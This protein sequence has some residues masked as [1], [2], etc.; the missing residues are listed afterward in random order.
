M[1]GVSD[2]V[3]T[4]LS[5]CAKGFIALSV[6][7]IYLSEYKGY[8]CSLKANTRV[9]MQSKR[10]MLFCTCQQIHD[11]S[12]INTSS[13]GLALRRTSLEPHTVV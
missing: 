10:L 5:A 3:S 7:T 8:C 1:K 2:E 4:C 9:L 11:M 13:T 12:K 6:T